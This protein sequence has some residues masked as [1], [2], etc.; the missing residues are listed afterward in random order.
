MP[1]D[2]RRAC[3]PAPLFWTLTQR[4]NQ[5]P[6]RGSLRFRNLFLFR[7]DAFIQAASLIPAKKKLKR[8]LT[9]AI[10]AEKITR[11]AT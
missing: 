7:L 11:S 10:F 9:L 4:V 2:L 8:Y 6:R 3:V 5:T 1:P